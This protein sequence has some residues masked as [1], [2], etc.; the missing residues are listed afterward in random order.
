[1]TQILGQPCEFQV[2]PRG[3]AAAKPPPPP[4]LLQQP[5]AAAAGPG[6]GE[7]DGISRQLATKKKAR[8]SVMELFKHPAVLATL[9]C[10]MASGNMNYTTSTWTP[11]YFVQV[12]GCTPL[13]A[14]AY[15]VWS[16]PVDI[17]GGFFVAGMESALLRRGVGQLAVRKGA[18]TACVVGRSI[19]LVLFGLAKTPFRAA[20]FINLEN[21]CSCLMG[22]G[23]SPNM[24]E[25][26]GEQTATMNA[27]GNTM[28]NF[29]GFAV[30]TDG[31]GAMPPCHFLARYVW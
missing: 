19:F 20:V 1:M 25:V 6:P 14:A 2:R 8:G 26:G 30:P 10:K 11:T 15:M 16:T 13:Q 21:V 17:V 7:V 22:A 3:A 31:G 5:V 29:F 24:I 18:Q 9:W 28:A 12:L 23:F 27:V 4:Q